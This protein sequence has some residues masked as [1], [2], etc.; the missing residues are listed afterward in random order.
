MVQAI[1]R[2]VWLCGI[3]C[4]IANPPFFSLCLVMLKLTVI[5]T[6]CA[7]LVSI[8]LLPDTP[9]QVYVGIGIALAVG[10]PVFCV[11]GLKGST[12]F[13]KRSG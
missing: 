11:I 8:F 3:E 12:R 2:T 6:V 5:I 1:L 9:D 7:T 10:I 4:S 13:I